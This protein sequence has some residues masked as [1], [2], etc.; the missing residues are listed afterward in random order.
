MHVHCLQIGE[1]TQ[2]FICRDPGTGRSKGFGFLEFAKPEDAMG[3]MML[4]GSTLG[5]PAHTTFPHHIPTHRRGTPSPIS[6]FPAFRLQTVASS[7]FPAPPAP[8]PLLSRTQSGHSTSRSEAGGV[9]DSAE[10][11]G[12]A[13]AA[14]EGEVGVVVVV[15]VGEGASM[16]TP[17]STLTS[18]DC[19]HPTSRQRPQRGSRYAPTQV[20]L[21]DG[22]HPLTGWIDA[23]SFVCPCVQAANGVAGDESAMDISNGVTEQPTAAA[24]GEANTEGGMKSNEDF[25]KMVL[26]LR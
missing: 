14:V 21:R 15:V 10:V 13:E 23:S 19:R 2:S 26:G 5:Q 11:G 3:A 9:A 6:L 25:R 18:R 1:V 16:S 24:A 8:S 20:L 12:A 7:P 4:N 22:S 17:D